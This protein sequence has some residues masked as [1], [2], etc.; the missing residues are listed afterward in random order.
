M[1]PVFLKVSQLN[2]GVVGSGNLAYDEVK[3]LKNISS[4]ITLFT[5]GNDMKCDF[6]NLDVKINSSKINKIIGE[7]SLE[8]LSMA[9]GEDISLDGLFIANSLN[10]TVF[11]STLGLEL[12]DKY[13]KVND[14]YMTNLENL[15]AIGDIVGEPMQIGKAVSDG[16]I[17][18]KEIIKYI[19]STK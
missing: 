14:K 15:Y 7:G 9:D 5:N 13:I 11:S 12:D 1:Y 8:K 18:S 10:A 4:D 2:I 6:S 19:R 17:L 3:Y 16:I